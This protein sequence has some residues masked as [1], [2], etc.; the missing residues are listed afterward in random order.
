MYCNKKL[1]VNFH[2]EPRC[3]M[4]CCYCFA[5]PGKVLSYKQHC[6]VIRKLADSHLFNRINF[7]GGEPTVSSLLLPLIKTAHHAGF[8]CSIVTN[9]FNLIHH[10]QQYENLY[11][12][13]SCIG[14]SVDSLREST[15]A[16]IGRRCN[17]QVITKTEY[18]HLCSTI[19]SRGIAL[20]INTVVS[21][22][23]V[24]E[25]FTGFYDTVQPDRIKLFQVLRPNTCVK[26][27]Y[28]NL[29]IA[30]TD[31]EA[32]VLR[33]KTAGRFSK[34]IVAEDNAAMTNAYYMLD[35]ECRFIDNKTNAQSP[36]IAEIGMT[37]EKALTYIEVDAAKY[38]ARYSA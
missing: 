29:M 32:F 21:K 15:N 1:T 20:K 26:H 24:D 9:G 16:A 13:L 8:D 4:H 34:R 36:S 35:S 27:H 11:P 2:F 31:F 19:K 23:N 5:P 30:K 7:V 12:Y 3:N 25:D 38:Q 17:C 33:H 10:P 28:N 22:L 18:E 6:T 37:V 14:I